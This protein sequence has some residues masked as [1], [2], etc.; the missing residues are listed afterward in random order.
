MHALAHPLFLFAASNDLFVGEDREFAI[1]TV[2]IRT[3]QVIGPMDLPGSNHKF[4]IA[5][6][7]V[8][9]RD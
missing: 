1:Q 5:R 9:L 7:D 2:L 6:S 8:R 4:I 3:M